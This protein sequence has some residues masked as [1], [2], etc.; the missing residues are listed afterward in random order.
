M[1]KGEKNT[2]IKDKNTIAYKLYNTEL[3][4]WERYRHRYEV[5]LDWLEKFVEAGIKFTGFDE[6]G[7]RMEILE[8]A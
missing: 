6:S 7:N 4:S 2:I 5:A 8:L 1:R 3:I